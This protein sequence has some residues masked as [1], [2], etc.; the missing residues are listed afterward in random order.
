MKVSKKIASYYFGLFAEKISA[1]YLN[2]KFYKILARRLKTP[3]GEID[4]I[5]QKGNTL[6]FIE[7]KARRDIEYIDFISQK[8]ISRIEK[9]AQYFLLKEKKYQTYN[10]RF[11]AIIVSKLFYPK[12]FINYWH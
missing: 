4:I 6:I 8:Q 7:V 12:H 2:I 10:I 11:D 3:F 1:L 9:A 5:A